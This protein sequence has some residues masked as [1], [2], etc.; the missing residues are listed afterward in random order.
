MVLNETFGTRFQVRGF[1]FRVANHMRSGKAV[2][3]ISPF[4]FVSAVSLCLVSAIVSLSPVWVLFCPKAKS[5]M[6]WAVSA[7]PCFSVVCLHLLSILFLWTH[8]QGL[9]WGM[10]CF[11]YAS[12]PQTTSQCSPYKY[13]NIR[14][15]LLPPWN[16]TWA[17]ALLCVSASHHHCPRSVESP[18]PSLKFHLGLFLFGHLI[19]PVPQR[20]GIV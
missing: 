18:L 8:V 5:L 16:S 7:L 2:V 20:L 9:G 6:S 19:K 1:F 12:V 15:L 14:E 17:L 11:G 3:L 10:M 13:P 4:G